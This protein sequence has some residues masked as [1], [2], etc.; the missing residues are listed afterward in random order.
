MAKANKRLELLLS[1]PIERPHITDELAGCYPAAD[2]AGAPEALVVSP[3]GKVCRV[4]LEQ[5]DDGVAFLGRGWPEF[6]AAHGIGVDWFVVVR[7][8]GGGA[9][10]VKVFD[11]SCCLHEFRSPAAVVT[12]LI[13]LQQYLTVSSSMANKN[14]N[15]VCWKPQFIR[16]MHPDF[17]EKMMIPAEFLKHYVTGEYL[18]SQIAIVLSPLGKFWRFKLEKDGSD[19]FSQATDI[20]KQHERDSL[21]FSRKRKSNDVSPCCKEKKR[22]N[23]SVSL[24]KKESSQKEPDYQTGPP[25]W[26]I[27]E[28]TTYA[29]KRALPLSVKFCRYVGFNTSCTI[30]LKTEMD[31][32]RSWKVHG[33]AYNAA[34]YL[35]DG[36]KTFCK[37]TMLK[38]GDVCTFNIVKTLL[39]HVTI[40]RSSIVT[41]NQEQKKSPP[42]HYSM[43]CM[44]KNGSSS[45]EEKGPDGSGASFRKIYTRSVY[46]IGP[47]SWIQKEMT[48]SSLQKHLFLAEAFFIA[49]GLKEQC[50][51]TLKTSIDSTKFW[52]VDVLKKMNGSYKLGKDWWMFCQDNRLKE[53]DICTF[54]VVEATLWQVIITRVDKP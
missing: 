10:T 40:K 12:I 43:H 46:E 45:I 17:M 14:N 49:I 7:H 27:K 13:S 42:A 28:I 9:L 21:S 24:L 26:I 41:D 11:T 37:D 8:E 48:I 2:G 1:P 34:H 33:L 18:K 47:P 31:S 5:D 22:T 6:L 53:G 20:E 16:V 4:E 36:W 44:T 29:L 51:I 54:E 39:W 52:Q 50:T 25:S 32:T 23:G 19:M 15:G 35:G 3:F 38:E 30:T